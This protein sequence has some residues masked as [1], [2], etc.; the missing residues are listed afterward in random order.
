VIPGVWQSVV[1]TLAVFRTV[2]LLGWDHLPTLVRA[3]KWATGEYT[4]TNGS[5]NARLRQT[6]E[7]VTEETRW[8]RP[9]LAALLAC[10]YCLGAYISVVWY[11]AWRIYPSWSLTVAAPFA[12]SAAVG[13]WARWI[14]P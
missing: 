4:V 7:P 8:R 2:R 6:N 1:L 9:T 10:P 12:L 5:T 11:V 14:D 3:R 13:A